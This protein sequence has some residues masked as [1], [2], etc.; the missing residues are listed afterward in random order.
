[1]TQI[2]AL[3][4]N[5]LLFQNNRVHSLNSVFMDYWFNM[6]HIE[7]K[8]INDRVCYEGEN[9]FNIFLEEIQV[10]Y[11]IKNLNELCT[12]KAISEAINSIS[13]CI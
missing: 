10:Q 9:N 6:S 11:Q 7:N 2:I 4:P 3:G 13:Q 5:F 12:V 8:T 1:M